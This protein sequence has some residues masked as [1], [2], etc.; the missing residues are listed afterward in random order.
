VGVLED[1]LRVWLKHQAFPQAEG[2]H[3]HHGMIGFRECLKEIVLVPVWCLEG[4]YLP[5][6]GG[7]EQLCLEGF[8]GNPLRLLAVLGFA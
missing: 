5:A 8:F 7:Q 3:I 4:G 1:C 6:F 2:V